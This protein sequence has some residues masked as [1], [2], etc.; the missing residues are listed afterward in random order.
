MTPKHYSSFEE[1]DKQ[2][3]I[4]KLKKAI[5]KEQLAYNYHKAKHLLYPKNIGLEIGNILQEKLINL[6]LNR[7]SWVF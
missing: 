4:L 5:E 6:L 7:F 2:L 3:N 1:I